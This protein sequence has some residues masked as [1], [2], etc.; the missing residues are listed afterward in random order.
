MPPSSRPRLQSS[1][2]DDYDL[3]IN[4]AAMM[5]QLHVGASLPE[6]P[7]RARPFG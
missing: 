5:G 7:E 1:C 3:S 6:T 4:R 2:D